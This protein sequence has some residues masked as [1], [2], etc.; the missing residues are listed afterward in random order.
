MNFLLSFP[1]LP[2]TRNTEV[3]ALGLAGPDFLPALLS[4]MPTTHIPVSLALSQREHTCHLQH[5]DQVPVAQKLFNWCWQATEG[6]NEVREHMGELGLVETRR[7]PA[8]IS[9]SQLLCPAAKP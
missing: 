8:P 3:A 9:E 7:K 6:N 4:S 5:T 1:L 2:T